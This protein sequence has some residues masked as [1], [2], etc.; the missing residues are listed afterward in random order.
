MSVS[1]CYFYDVS[2]MMSELWCKCYQCLDVYVMMSWCWLS[3]KNGFKWVMSMSWCWS[4]RKNGFKWFMSKSWCQCH[5]VSFMIPVSWCQCLDL[6]DMMSVLWHQCHND[7][8]THHWT[9][10]QSIIKFTAQNMR[11]S[12]N[13]L[14]LSLVHTK[15]AGLHNNNTEFQCSLSI[16]QHCLEPCLHQTKTVSPESL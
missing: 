16:D 1:W 5:D 14:G 7:S 15:C 9:F 3:R 4:S 12:T 8:F 10:N 2:A 6:S 13:L 11:H